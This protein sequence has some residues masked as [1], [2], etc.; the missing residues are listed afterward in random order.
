MGIGGAPDK[1][2]LTIALEGLQ[3][4][5]FGPV[6]GIG[7]AGTTVSGGVAGATGAE[8]VVAGTTGAGVGLA[9]AFVEL[10]LSGGTV[11]FG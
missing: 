3:S 11:S 5:V 7:A 8:E 9:I 10:E 6:F 4:P 1:L 2:S